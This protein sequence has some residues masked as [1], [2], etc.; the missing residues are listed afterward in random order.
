MYATNLILYDVVLDDCA[1]GYA[2]AIA[3]GG[4]VLDDL[5]APFDTYHL[6][7]Q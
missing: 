5:P 6:A 7:I 4:V 1:A 2:E 3:L